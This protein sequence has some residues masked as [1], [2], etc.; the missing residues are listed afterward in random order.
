[1]IRNA[2]LEYFWLAFAGLTLACSSPGGPDV[3]ADTQADGPRP[4]S[5]VPSPWITAIEPHEGFND[6]PALAVTPSGQVFVGWISYRDGADALA[7]ARY[8]HRG[9]RFVKEDEWLAL[10]GKGTYLLDLE[11]VATESG[12]HFVFAREIDGDWDVFAVGVDDG[13]PSEPVRIA[14]GPETQIKPA[15]AWHDG[16]LFVSWESNADSKRRIHAASLRDGVV[17]AAGPL[18]GDSASNYGPSVAAS[19]EGR[20]SVAWHSF[21]DHNYDVYLRQRSPSGEWDQ[22][23]RLTSSPGIDRHARLL[24][25]EGDLWVVYEH[26][27]M[28]EYFVGRTD[29]R[30]L[31]AARITPRG[32]ESPPGYW[33]S[34]PLATN[35]SEAGS[36]AFDPQGRLWIAYQQPREPRG[37]WAV[38]I[39]GYTGEDWIGPRGLSQRRSMDRPPSMAPKGNRLLIAFQADTFSDTWSQSDPDFTDNARSQI[40]LASVDTGQSPAA[41]PSMHLAALEEPVEPFDPAV[42]HAS[43]GEDAETESI[44][45]NGEQFHLYYGELHEHSDISICNRCGDQSLDEEYQCRRDINR[46]DF[47][48]MTDHGY[49]IVPYLWNY[50]AKMVR[51]NHDAGRL[52]TFLGEEWTSS[53]EDY[54]DERPWGYYGHRNLVFADPYFPRWWNAYNGDSP[55]DLWEELRRMNADFVQ[56]PHQLADSGNVP[57]DWTYADEE[58]QPVAEIFQTRGSYEYAGAPRH[59]RTAIGKPSSYIHEAWSQGLKIGVIASPDH[60]GGV[61]KAAVWAR[62]KTRAGILEAIRARRTFGT[63]AARI[64]IDLRVNGHIMGEVAQRGE[65]PV[66]VTAV[67]RAPQAIQSIEVCRNNRFVYSTNPDTSESSIEYVDQAPPDGPAYY[68]LRVIQ[69]DGEI[70]WSSPVWL[71]D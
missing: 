58:A 65:G 24:A 55:A 8:S 64:L 59:A 5:P 20:V 17:T 14:A 12:A 21:R 68:Y 41:A 49:N 44:E 3:T 1:M 19:P 31:V 35:R 9:D 63:T 47:V 36:A 32:L 23:R 52:V 27:R 7:I 34:S 29:E 69:T 2:F 70:A 50:S 57:V 38:R 53:F 67:V 22:V 16:T 42:L 51:A 54:D 28:E 40:L 18:S 25:H 13:G 10:G 66:T 4:P 62:E 61:G 26:A 56:I 46:L 71:E 60:G 45:Y 15:P 39:A 6:E 33:N 37:G 30:H 11:A 48:A 43:Y